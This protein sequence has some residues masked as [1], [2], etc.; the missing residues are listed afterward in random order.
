MGDSVGITHFDFHNAV[1][2]GGHESVFREIRHVPEM[3][4]LRRVLQF[5]TGA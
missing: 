5:I 1:R 2:I 3:P 4:T